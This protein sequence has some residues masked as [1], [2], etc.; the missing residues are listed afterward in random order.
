[1]GYTG[2]SALE[3]TLPPCPMCFFSEM[4][5]QDSVTA[6][7]RTHAAYVAAS[8]TAAAAGGGAAASA[9][10]ASGGGGATGGGSGAHAAHIDVD[11]MYRVPSSL[12]PVFG[13]LLALNKERLLSEAE[14]GAALLAYSKANNAADPAD[15]ADIASVVRV[16][17]DELLAGS[18]YGKKEPEGPG[19]AVEAAPLLVR[20]L[21]KLNQFTRLRITRAGTAVE[22]VLQKGVVK[23]IRVQAEDRHAGRKHVTRVTGMEQFAIEPDELATRIQ[24]THNTSCSVQPLP[25]KNETGKEVAALGMLL[26][27]VCVLLREAY[28]IPETYLEIVDK[29]K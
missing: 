23:N 20:L 27:E 22:E 29:T 6:V 26:N 25:G 28:G 5:S 21:G 8:E 2:T 4:R 24:K 13:D 15:A 18:L 9:G 3:L 17:L 1:M 7:N 16:T 11:V 10:A 19:T 12:R 14:V